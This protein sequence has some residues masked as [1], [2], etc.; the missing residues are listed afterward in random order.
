MSPDKTKAYFRYNT[1]KKNQ[2]LL[3][4]GNHRGTEVTQISNM[5]NITLLK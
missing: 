3:S 2:V 5:G 1:F 4:P